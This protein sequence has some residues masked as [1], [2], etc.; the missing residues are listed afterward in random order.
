MKHSRQIRAIQNLEHSKFEQRF[1]VHVLNMF[2][3]QIVTV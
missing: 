1:N 3:I 2:G